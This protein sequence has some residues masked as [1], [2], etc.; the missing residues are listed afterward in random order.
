MRYNAMH[1]T[2][3]QIE[4]FRQAIRNTFDSKQEFKYGSV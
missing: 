2:D 4:E 1:L 3:P